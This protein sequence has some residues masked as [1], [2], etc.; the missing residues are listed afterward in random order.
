VLQD[1]PRI[2]QQFGSG[3]DLRDARQSIVYFVML[4]IFVRVVL[5][6]SQTQ[7]ALFLHSRLVQQEIS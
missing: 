3:I 4:D 5:H 7:L 6:P 2:Y 1:D